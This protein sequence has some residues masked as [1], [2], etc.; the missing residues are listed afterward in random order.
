MR[1]KKHAVRG[2]EPRTLA[3]GLLALVLFA[4]CYIHQSRYT[5][6][7]AFSR[8]ALLE[9]V[10]SHGRLEIDRYRAKTSDTALVNGHHYSDKAPG[11]AALALPAF[12]A[13]ARVQIGRASCR[14]RV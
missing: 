1:V 10:V 11:T 4:L 5:F 7:T 8:L 6:A 9:T 2:N 3:W 14:E 13:A 12:A